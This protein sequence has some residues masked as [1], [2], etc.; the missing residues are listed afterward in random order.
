MSIDYRQLIAICTQIW[1]EILRKYPSPKFKRKAVMNHYTRLMST[2]WKSDNPKDTEYQSAA[3]LLAKAANDLGPIP[4]EEINL[5]IV[6]GYQA[7]AFCIPSTLQ[8]WRG[9]IREIMM[10]SA[11]KNSFTNPIPDFPLI[12]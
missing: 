10:D 4:V 5:P 6:A 12:G 3:K 9:R 11:C 2:Q 8:K 1:E 7:L